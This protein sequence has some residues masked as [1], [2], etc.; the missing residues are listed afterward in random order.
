MVDLRHKARDAGKASLCYERETCLTQF[1]RAQGFLFTDQP[2]Q[3]TAQLGC[4]CAGLSTFTMSDRNGETG[5]T[6]A[7]VLAIGPGP[8]TV[9]EEVLGQL[10]RL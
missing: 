8:A 2:R 9:M 7:T 4:V 1:V 6:H 10:P 3:A 5:H